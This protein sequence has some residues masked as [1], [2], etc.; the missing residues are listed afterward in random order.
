[1]EETQNNV[2]K[3]EDTTQIQEKKNNIEN[4]F[5]TFSIITSIFLISLIIYLKVTLENFK[6]CSDLDTS[7]II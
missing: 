4:M 2:E 3:I 7:K 1:M 6:S 5:K